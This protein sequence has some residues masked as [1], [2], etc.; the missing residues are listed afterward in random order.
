MEKKK[1]SIFKII[2][3]TLEVLVCLVMLIISIFTLTSGTSEDKVSNTFG[4]STFTVLSDSMK[5]VFK[6]GDLVY[7]KVLTS[8]EVKELKEGQIITFW[9]NINGYRV[10][11]T[12]RIMDINERLTGT[13]DSQGNPLVELMFTTGGD[14]NL[15]SSGEV[16]VDSYQV[17]E[18][19]VVALYKGKIPV[20]GGVI[21]FMTDGNNYLFFII[22]PLIAL[23]LWNAYYFI[24]LIFKDK[25]EKQKVALQEAQ[26]QSQI[27]QQALIEEAKR[28]LLEEMK[29]NQEVTKEEPKEK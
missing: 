20:I 21:K 28:Q 16:I 17:S 26:A 11:N 5:P 18:S 1:K 3:T 19:E 12:H 2:G 15:T 29:K 24:S 6:E 14:N 8:G 10:L 27:D 9:T 23:F 7:G 22:L 4:Y 25:M 13:S